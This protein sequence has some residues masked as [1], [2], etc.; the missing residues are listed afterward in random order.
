MATIKLYFDKR[1]ERGDKTYPLKFIVQHK[2]T[3]MVNLKIYLME[4]Q[5]ENDKV[6]NHPQQRLL[7]RELSNKM[8]N[9]EQLLIQ[10]GNKI[11]S[12]SNAQLKKC[13][14][15]DRVQTEE[16]EYGYRLAEHF[17]K[18]ISQ[19]NKPR[20]ADMY[21]GT[22]NKILR[23]SK[24]IE[25]TQIDFN[26]LKDFEQH[27]KL[28]CGVNTRSI[29]FRNI[30]A[31]FND[32]INR[33]LV[34]QE[35]YPFRKFKIKNEKTVKRSLTVDEL[36]LVR[37]YPIAEFME[38]YRDMFMLTFY[39]MG[40]NFIDLVNLKESNLKD[41]R[42][43]YKREKTGHDYDIEV[44]PEAM[45]IIERHRGK[46]YLLNVRDKYS[47]HRDY[48]HRLNDNL[49]RIGKVKMVMNDAKDP[50]KRKK[51]KKKYYPLF[52]DLT[53]YF[54]RHSWASIAGELEIP[55]ET[56]SMA[57][58]HEIG[59]KTT[60]IYYRFNQKKIDEA[61]RKVAEYLRNKKPDL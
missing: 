47:D 28:T 9:A 1:N 60:W 57:L 34:A 4:D 33:D 14:E 12:M 24:D 36:A 10:L 49:Q 53:T 16:Y 40:I 18:F 61:N 35:C 44:L 11:K 25:F 54:A 29:H 42:I 26:W 20:T 51:N 31:V 19:C 6:T 30:R 55:I 43:K 13:I 8:V 38:K 46:N 23:Y 45:E 50:S 39:L 59:S 32:A 15:T 41:G 21:Q 56:I 3:F 7:N 17:E 2:G 37:D 58:G 52:P 27:L 48:L 5:W 22:L